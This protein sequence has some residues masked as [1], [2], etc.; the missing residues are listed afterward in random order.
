MKL[1]GD[2]YA[3]HW[4][5]SPCFVPN[6][7]ELGQLTP[8]VK[9]LWQWARQSDAARLIE[10]D[11][12][13][14]VTLDPEAPPDGIHTVL[15]GQVEC[16][17]FGWDAWSRSLP[18]L[19]RWAFSDLMISHATQ[20]ASVG[21]HRD[22]YD[23]FLIQL[24]G[25]RAWQLGT[26]ADANLAEADQG[27]SRLLQGFEP[28]QSHIAEP[29]DLLYV[30]PGCGH[31]GVA[32]DDECMTLSV[33]FRQPSLA[34]VLEHLSQDENTPLVVDT[35]SAPPGFAPDNVDALRQQLMNWIEQ[36]SDTE[37]RQ[38][39]GLAATQWSHSDSDATGDFVRFAPGVR[40]C[41]ISQNQAAV[42]GEIFHLT[43]ASLEALCTHGLDT[44]QQDEPTQESLQEFHAA[45]WLEDA[46]KDL[47]AHDFN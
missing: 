16:L 38:A 29:G 4:Q 13:F 10:P 3:T 20:G 32:L 22:R 37:L 6:A 36:R 2:F 12:N 43:A 33:G 25:K 19:G 44:N 15:V 21:A 5:Q 41:Q 9:Q 47:E 31:H 11:N 35:R 18:Q 30:P 34:A 40:A 39:W 23:V 17:D 28:V 46:T 42:M 24:A 14:Q 7:C 8:S 26:V 1:P 27:G 45:G